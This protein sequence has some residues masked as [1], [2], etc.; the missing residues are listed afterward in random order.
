M[1]KKNPSNNS[2]VGPNTSSAPSASSGSRNQR[3]ATTWSADAGWSSAMHA[4]GSTISASAAR[5]KSGYKF[6]PTAMT[7]TGRRSN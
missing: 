1:A 4:V 6:V 7:E 3:A 5:G 2:S